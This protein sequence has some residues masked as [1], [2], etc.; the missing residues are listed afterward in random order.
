MKKI[1]LSLLVLSMSQAASAAMVDGVAFHPSQLPAFSTFAGAETGDE[2]FKVNSDPVVATLLFELAGY[3]N[4]NSFGIYE[5][6][7]PLNTL[8]VFSGSDSAVL[9]KTVS[10]STATDVC[11]SGGGCASNIDKNMFGFYLK[12]GNGSTYFSQAALNGGI[13]QMW[14]FFVNGMADVD[15]VLGFEDKVINSD[16]DHNDF[17]VGI[18]SVKAVPLPAAVW[19]F[20]TALMGFLG[21]SRRK[22]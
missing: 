16:K 18:K 10:W 9:S 7:N 15:Y 14:S 11:V 12:S 17:I 4:V 6:S 21:F 2:L 1:L 19:M 20:G 5:V 8:E 3:S 22:I 13:D